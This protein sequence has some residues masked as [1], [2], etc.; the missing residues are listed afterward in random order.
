M[1]EELF[2][3]LEEIFDL[4]KHYSEMLGRQQIL[5]KSRNHCASRESYDE[6]N[7][8]FRKVCDECI[9]VGN[10]LIEKEKELERF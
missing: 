10:L 7:D 1:L 3:L 9:R 6:V 8:E 4:Q 5:L 2:T